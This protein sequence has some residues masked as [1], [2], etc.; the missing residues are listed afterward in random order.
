MGWQQFSSILAGKGIVL[1]HS[2]RIARGSGRSLHDLAF[3]EGHDA[4]APG[5]KASDIGDDF[6][7]SV[8]AARWGEYPDQAEGRA[9]AALEAEVGI[10][11]RGKVVRTPA[12]GREAAHQRR[13]KILG[14]TVALD[15]K[16]SSRRRQ[17]AEGDRRHRPAGGIDRERVQFGSSGT[18]SPTIVPVAISL[19]SD[20]L[21]PSMWQ[22]AEQIL[23]GLR[24]RAAKS[25]RLKRKARVQSWVCQQST[26]GEPGLPLNKMIHQRIRAVRT[27]WE[28]NAAWGMSPDPNINDHV[29]LRAEYAAYRA[30]RRKAIKA[31]GQDGWKLAWARER[32]TRQDEQARLRRSLDVKRSLLIRRLRRGRL[33]RVWLEGLNLRHRHKLAQL[34]ARQVERWAGTRLELRTEQEHERQLSYKVWLLTRAPVDAAAARQYAWIDTMEARRSSRGA[35]PLDAVETSLAGPCRDGLP[36]FGQQLDGEDGQTHVCEQSGQLPFDTKKIGSDAPSRVSRR[37]GVRRNGG[38]RER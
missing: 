15:V 25:R 9:R 22:V 30:Q 20:V 17:A 12:E 2:V 36:G 33:R 10:P 28:T 32:G 27:Q 29:S 4:D 14:S 3:A 31:E 21:L 19:G 23:A 6:R 5:C 7:Y 24:A 13:V 38:D 8:L 16:M 18:G 1:K 37:K 35:A 26:P 11:S 34:K